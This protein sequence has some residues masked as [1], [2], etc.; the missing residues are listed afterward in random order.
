[1]T[2]A[3][4][5]GVIAYGCLSFK[6]KGSNTAPSFQGETNVLPNIHLVLRM[7]I[8]MVLKNLKQNTFLFYCIIGY[9]FDIKGQ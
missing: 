2:A 6:M 9:P 8:L 7:R 5:N 4:S 3:F 1:M